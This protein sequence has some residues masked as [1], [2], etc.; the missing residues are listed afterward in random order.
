MI[1]IVADF[2]DETDKTIVL[3]RRFVK[4]V[5]QKA[6]ATIKKELPEEAQTVEVMECIISEI[7]QT[8]KERKIFL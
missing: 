2:T 1:E 8:V 3:E 7:N 6:I 4:A 5:V